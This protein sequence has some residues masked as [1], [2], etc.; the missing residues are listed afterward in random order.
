[1]R[2]K[3]FISEAR[4]TKPAWFLKEKWEI[5]LLLDA[6][7]VDNTDVYKVNGLN[8]VVP[9]NKSYARLHI[10][11]ENMIERGGKYYFG[12]EIQAV[13]SFLEIAVEGDIGSLRGIS[14]YFDQTIYLT[15]KSVVFDQLPIMQRGL[16]LGFNE[17]V[18]MHSLTGIHK[19]KTSLD[20]VTIGDKIKECILG[21]IVFDYKTHVSQIKPSLG[22]IFQLKEATEI[23]CKHLQENNNQ[24]DILDCKE[25]LISKGYKEYA[26]L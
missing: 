19:A 14:P 4:S 20:Y 24:G 12:F 22:K 15:A 10:T 7:K 8:R 9:A 6:G 21:L 18:G 23:M 1:M 3:S 16:A 11:E 17:E 25:A 5:E 13:S 26:K 2:F